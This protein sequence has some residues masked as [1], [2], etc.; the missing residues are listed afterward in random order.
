MDYHIIG[1]RECASE[2]ARYLVTIEGMDIQDPMRLRLM[3]HLQCFIS[4]REL[5]AK[6]SVNTNWCN[7]YPSTYGT[8]S[9]SSASSTLIQQN[10]TPHNYSSSY[11]LSSSYPNY[12]P[13]YNSEYF[14]SE[15]A[16]HTNN[17]H[18]NDTNNTSPSRVINPQ[19]EHQPIYTELTSTNEKGHYEYDNIT[20]Q[21]F[22]N[23][24]NNSNNSN[25]VYR[26]WHPDTMAY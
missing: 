6:S 26:P 10:S 5:S 3:S 13:H 9:S 8:S 7:S 19:Q 11:V 1:F 24:S 25:L 14:S 15:Q 12:M 23:N 2:V 22:T 18:S 17:A 4:Q 20:N 16:S 21:P